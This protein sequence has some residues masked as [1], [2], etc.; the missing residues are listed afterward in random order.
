[1]RE[2]ERS[3][4]AFYLDIVHLNKTGSDFTIRAVAGALGIGRPSPRD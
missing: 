1:M 4:Q 2:S 3:G